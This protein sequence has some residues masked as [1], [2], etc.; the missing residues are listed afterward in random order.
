MVKCIQCFSVKRSIP[1]KENLIL[2]ENARDE[3]GGNVPLFDFAKVVG[4]VFV[5]DK[6]NQLRMDAI[7]KAF[8]VGFCVVVA[9]CEGDVLS[10]HHHLSRD[11]RSLRTAAGWGVWL[12]P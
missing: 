6:E 2:A 4:P 11:V 8:C 1:F 7:Q 12:H 9:N 10:L 5:F 3:I